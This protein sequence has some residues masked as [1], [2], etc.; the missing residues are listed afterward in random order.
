MNSNGQ[1]VDFLV[2]HHIGRRGG[3]IRRT[4]FS[5]SLPQWEG[6]TLCASGARDSIGG[7]KVFWVPPG[8]DHAALRRIGCSSGQVVEH[9]TVVSVVSNCVHRL[10]WQGDC[11]LWLATTVF[12]CTAEHL[13]RQPI[14]SLPPR[15]QPRPVPYSP[16]V[17]W[18]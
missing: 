13:A 3:S 17:D 1:Q 14:R 15:I 8:D 6:W 11:C 4:A 7:L 18:E 12:Q 16:L 9:Q 2:L 10:G 5:R